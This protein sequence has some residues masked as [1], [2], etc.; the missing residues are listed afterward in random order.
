MYEL[1]YPSERLAPYIENYWFVRGPVELTVDVFV[2]ARADLILNFGAPY[3][4]KVAGS[5]A[6]RQQ[7]SN[8]DAQ[9]LK[10]IRIVQ[11]GDV[12]ISG[13][14]FRTGGLAP[15]ARRSVH[16]WNNRVI[17]L[18]RAFDLALEPGP[19]DEQK[20]ALD[21]FFEKRMRVTSAV[22]EFMRVK[23]EIERRG[24]L[25]RIDAL[26]LSRRQI[27]RLFRRYLGFAPKTFSRIVRFQAALSRLKSDPGCTLAQVA[28][29]CGYYDQSHFVRDHKAYAGRAPKRQVG[30]FPKTAPE[31]F[32]PNLVQFVQDVRRA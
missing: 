9:R 23:N 20:A 15:F 32:S 26:G 31:D 3:T 5:R 29:E 11:K 25:A 4:R 24:G 8:L 1:R 13:V 10:P 18:S 27:D 22:R 6:K 19:I 28:A 12:L 14:R 21:A 2:D 7:A 30:Y 16:E 17:P